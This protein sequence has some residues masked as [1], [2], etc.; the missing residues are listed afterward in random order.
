M[1]MSMLVHFPWAAV[2]MCFWKWSQQSGW[3]RSNS[4]FNHQ[5]LFRLRRKSEAHDELANRDRGS[6]ETVWKG[7]CGRT[8]LLA[9][10]GRRNLRVPG[11]ERRRENDDHSHVAGDDQTHLGN[12]SGASHP[13]SPGESATL[14]SGRI[15]GGD[16]AQLSGVNRL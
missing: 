8:S 16:A 1:R 4:S 6:W 15:P 9:R 3:V 12:G 13:G 14:G 7:H 2:S 5:A 10:G 11:L